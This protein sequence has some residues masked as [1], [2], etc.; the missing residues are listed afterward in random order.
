MCEWVDDEAEAGRL[1]EIVAK[2]ATTIDERR[3]TAQKM[4]GR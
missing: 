1:D 4:F 3:K 2:F